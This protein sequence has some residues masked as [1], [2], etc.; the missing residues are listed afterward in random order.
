MDK[1]EIVVNIKDRKVRILIDTGASRSVI[2][3]T[4]AKSLK[5]P[6]NRNEQSS[7]VK[8]MV[9]DGRF[10]APLGLIDLTL[11]VNGLNLPWSFLVLPNLAQRLIIGMDFLEANRA[12]IDIKNK[13]ITFFDGLTAAELQTAGQQSAK[14]YAL[15]SS[16][17]SLPP[18]TESIVQVKVPSSLHDKTIMCEPLTFARGQKYIV[19]RSIVKPDNGYTV[20]KILNP[21]NRA[22]CLNKNKP[23]ATLEMVLPETVATLE[24]QSNVA[25]MVGNEVQ[26]DLR[27]VRWS[28][29]DDR[30]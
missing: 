11:K 8:L 27:A 13:F 26:L 1:N 21:T 28:P 4:F 7:P 3:D 9:A 30:T 16:E 12:C 15:L 29:A 10:V 14:E 20:C 22:I 23:I 25:G 18:A 17:I 2:S 19:A 24:K 6:I 5:I